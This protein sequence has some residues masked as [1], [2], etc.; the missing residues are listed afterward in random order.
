[1]RWLTALFLYSSVFFLGI[2]WSWVLDLCLIFVDL[3]SIFWVFFWGVAYSEPQSNP[4]LPPVNYNH[5]HLKNIS[6][7]GYVDHQTPKSLS[8][9]VRGP[10]SLQ[11]LGHSLSHSS[12]ISGSFLARLDLLV[13]LMGVWGAE[14]TSGSTRTGGGSEPG[15]HVTWS[16]WGMRGATRSIGSRK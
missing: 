2:Y 3:L 14:L 4:L 12:L 7:Q 16:G 6:P 1:V 8:Q 11:L 9:M 15:K 5:K 13:Q 10:F